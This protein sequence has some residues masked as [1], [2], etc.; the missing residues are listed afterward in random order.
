VAGIASGDLSSLRIRHG[1]ADWV[2][3]GTAS[4]AGATGTITFLNDWTLPAST[5]LDFE[6][7]GTAA[8]LVAGDALTVSLAPA[9]FVLA[10]GAMGASTITGLPHTAGVGPPLDR[11]QRP[12]GRRPRPLQFST[13]TAGTWSA[14]A[15]AIASGGGGRPLHQKSVV[16]SPDRNLVA[17]VFSE[18]NPGSRDNLY[19]TFFDAANWDDGAGAPFGDAE[20]LGLIGQLGGFDTRQFEVAWEQKSG[21][22]SW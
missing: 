6:L 10:P 13:N 20:D 16:L 4:I 2:T 3:G 17:A 12:L 18:T 7:W 19:A 5:M 21:E 9:G 8:N 1:T 14:A 22:S 11:L 15:T